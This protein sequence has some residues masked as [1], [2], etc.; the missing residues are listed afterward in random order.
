M[1]KEGINM[2]DNEA[3]KYAT[4]AGGCFWCMVQPFERLEGVREVLTGY[5]G[6]YRESP[7]YMQVSMGNTGHFEAVRIKYDTSLVSYDKLLATFWKQIDPTDPVGQFAD[8]GLQYRTAIF[9]HDE[10]QRQLAESSK[11]KLQKSGKFREPI[12]VK[13][14]EASAFY[15]AE[16][17]HQ[18]YHRKN[19]DQYRR[20]KYGSGRAKY[21]EETWGGGEA[22]NG[23]K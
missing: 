7:T 14:L 20:Y 18:D 1:E 3:F 2:V 9:Y 4:F 17:Y 6:G 13:I 21:L 22:N 8:K 19:P 10:E 23:E 12:A 11:E 16:E 15:P 5:T